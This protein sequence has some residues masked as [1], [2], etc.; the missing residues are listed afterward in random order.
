MRVWR[1]LAITV[2]LTI[3][4]TLVAAW[5]VVRSP[6]EIVFGHEI[7]GRHHDAYTVMLQ[8]AGPGTSGTYAQPVTDRLGWLFARAI[9]PVSAYNLLVLL[10]F[11][12]TAG[13]TYLLARHLVGSHMAALIAA[14]AFTFAPVR[15]AHASSP[16]PRPQAHRGAARPAPGR[17]RLRA[18][19]GTGGT[20]MQVTRFAGP[21]DEWDAFGERHGRAPSQGN[22]ASSRR[23]E[24]LPKGFAEYPRGQ[25]AGLWGRLSFET[26]AA[27][28][29]QDE[30]ELMLS[31]FLTL[32]SRRRRRL[33]G[34]RPRLHPIWS[35][36]SVTSTRAH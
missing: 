7:V 19:R 24:A 17:I 20:L 34:A 11:P 16:L 25:H 21:A 36:N 30:A 33:E 26:G 28:P 35:K 29:P 6:A 5:P 31:L 32:R 18:C 15:L 9:D 23:A 12:L 1:G 2:G 4:V 13:A 14:L 27:H 22:G 8:I 3:A 10:S